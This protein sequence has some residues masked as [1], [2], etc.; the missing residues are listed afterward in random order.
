MGGAAAEGGSA[1]R[2]LDQTPTWAVASVC[3]VII[4]ISI[5]LEKALH[6]IG[7]WFTKRRKKPLFEA[8]EKLMILGFISLLM[9]FGQSYITKICISHAAADTMLPCRLK[10]ETIDMEGDE[11]HDVAPHHRL[12]SDSVVD[13]GVKRRV[14]VGGETGSSCPKGKVSLISMNGLHQLHIFIFFLAVFHVMYSAITMA[15]GRA[16]IRGWKMWERDASSS[17]GEFSNDPSKFRFSHE[18]SFVKQH[19]S[20]LNRVPVS[21]YA[22][23]FFRQFFRSVR[24]AD[25]LALRH[26][27][28]TAHLAP[29]ISFNF[30]KY[31]KRSLED[32]FKVV[33]GISPALWTSA[34]IFLLLNIHGEL[35]L[36]GLPHKTILAV[37][38]KLQAII[39]RMAIEIKERHAVIQ[40][41]PLVQLSDHHFWFGRPHLVL[42]LIHLSLFQNTFQIIYFLWIWYEFGLNSC[43]HNNFKLLVARVIMGVAVQF[44]CSYIT[45]PLYALVSQ[46][47]SHMK[48]SIFDEQTSKALMKWRQAVKKKQGKGPNKSPSDSPSTSPREGSP[49][50]AQKHQLHRFKSMGNAGVNPMPSRRRCHPEQDAL[51]D[52]ETDD[53]SSA[54]ATAVAIA[55]LSNTDL[56][57]GSD[58]Y[59]LPVEK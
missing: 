24:K 15:L 18:T 58:E 33:V 37:G 19:T 38:T 14:L 40:G 6:H 27:F 23:S 13:L 59:H 25:Y 10:R 53:P 52:T 28:V 22:V 1:S 42:F 49:K 20:Y 30:Q 9:T 43:F 35:N 5:L 47:G 8:L 36:E 21:F 4:L 16:K 54:A 32:D 11:S 46:M 34:L 26:G 51:S 45:L 31:I 41:I 29:G 39:S 57:T 50:A 12:L 17:D 7:E 48:K 3:A 56:L 2:E 44:L 55:N